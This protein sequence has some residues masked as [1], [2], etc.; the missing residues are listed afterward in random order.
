MKIQIESNDFEEK[1]YCHLCGSSFHPTEVVAQAYKESGEYITN[2]CP[3]CIAVGEGGIRQRM[4]RRAQSLR[5][6]ASELEKL[7]AEEIESPSLDRFKIIT[8]IAKAL[9]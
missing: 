4:R 6:I 7:A 9:R 8:Q 3:Q 2:V 5:A 1:S